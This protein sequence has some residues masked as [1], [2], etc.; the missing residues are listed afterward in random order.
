M[1][2]HLSSRSK[3]WCTHAFNCRVERTLYQMTPSLS[4]KQGKGYCWLR[5]QIWVE[6]LRSS[7]R[8]VW[9]P[10][11]PRL[12]ALFLVS[13]LDS[14]QSIGS[15]PVLEH[16]TESWRERVPSSSRWRRPRT[17]S[18]S[19]PTGLWQSSTSLAEAPQPLT[20]ILSP[21]PC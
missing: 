4:Q 19:L 20:V 3:K 15:S 16:P 10:S 5:A 9:P 12:A 21:T 8:T 14:H 2:T 11:W 18:S 7:D 13:P 1:R 6:S 17:S